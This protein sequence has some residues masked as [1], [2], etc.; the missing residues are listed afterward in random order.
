MPLIR[1]EIFRGIQKK[2]LF[3]S[4]SKRCSQ[5]NFALNYPFNWF[6]KYIYYDFIKIYDCIEINLLRQVKEK[7]ELPDEKFIE[8]MKNL[9][10]ASIKYTY[11]FTTLRT[12][13]I[14]EITRTRKHNG[15]KIR[16]QIHSLSSL[17]KWAHQGWEKKNFQS[18]RKE[19]AL[20]NQLLSPSPASQED[21][22]QELYH[23]RLFSSHM[24]IMLQQSRPSWAQ[25]ESLLT[26]R[27]Q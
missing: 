17:N 3:I 22:T 27:L 14:N 26:V 15:W 7:L 21:K 13:E 18:P 16:K 20:G 2:C 19:T 4:I 9:N 23:H 5:S 25:K 1:L 10:Q 11:Y 8:N 6:L 24:L 12:W